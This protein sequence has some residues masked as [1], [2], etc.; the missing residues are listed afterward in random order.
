MAMGS[1]NVT[2]Y[3]KWTA[4]STFT[5]TYLGNGN[6]GGSIPI[7]STNYEQGQ[8]VTVMGNTGNLVKTGYAFAGWNTQ[9]DGSGTT[10]A[11]AQTFTMGSANVTYAKWNIVQGFAYVANSGSGNSR[12]T[13]S[14]QTDL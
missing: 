14:A 3:A 1:A 2:L 13:R 9:A 5:V 7:D 6:T 4:N 12:S 8:T 10:Y 11:Q